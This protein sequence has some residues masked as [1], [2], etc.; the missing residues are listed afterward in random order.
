MPESGSSVA[1]WGRDCSGNANTCVISMNKSHIVTAIFN[2]VYSLTVSKQGTGEG[3][4]S[5]TPTGIN[6]GT[7]CTDNYSQDSSI[8]LKAFVDSSSVFTGWTGDCATVNGDMCTVNMSAA[9]AVIA[10]FLKRAPDFVITA[11]KLEPTI[12]SPLQIFTAKVTIKNQG[13]LIGGKGVSLRV[14]A[15]RPQL[16]KCKAASD[17]FIADIG[18]LEIG[19]SK[20]LK[21]SV[22]TPDPAGR[23]TLR[24]FIDSECKINESKESNNQRTVVYNA[25]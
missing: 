23:N 6:C 7:D 5:S 4:V 13:I 18:N 22:K 12:P 25:N 21:I 3:M 20:T 19:Q 16:A 2:T 24:A 15:H 14:W 17:A 10:T 1:G 8:T 11:L 9:K